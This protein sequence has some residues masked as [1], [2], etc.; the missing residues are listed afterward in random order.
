[1]YK[2][3][4]NTLRRW[5]CALVLAICFTVCYGLF[6]LE[7][8]RG[9]SEKMIRL[10]VVA[11]SDSEYEQSVKLEVRDSVLELLT[12]RLENAAGSESAAGIITESLGELERRARE[13]SGLSAT[14]TLEYEPFPTRE[15]DS[16]SLPAGEYLSLRVTLGEGGGRNWWC[17]VFP[18]L[19]M[20][21]AEEPAVAADSLTDEQLRLITEDGGE[22]V[23]RFKVLEYIEKIRGFFQ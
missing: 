19:C 14:A 7:S 5:E 3:D 12:P 21:I 13:I 9:L 10:H 18:P 15:Y 23:L 20:S 11:Q 8:Q 4:K 2:N 1:M 6:A 17:V 16:F 22:Y